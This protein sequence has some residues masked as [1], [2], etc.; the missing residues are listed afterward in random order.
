MPPSTAHS[1]VGPSPSSIPLS[2]GTSSSSSSPSSMSSSGATFSNS[3]NHSHSSLNTAAIAGITAAAVLIVVFTAGVLAYCVWRR[4]RSRTYEQG[5]IDK[6]GNVSGAHHPAAVAPARSSFFPDPYLVSLSP[7]STESRKGAPLSASTLTHSQESS[8][9]TPTTLR[10]NVPFLT[11]T[12]SSP[13][14]GTAY[15][16][17]PAAYMSSQPVPREGP[18]TTAAAFSE[19]PAR[20]ED[21]NP[22]NHDGHRLRDGGGSTGR[23]YEGTILSRP[24]GAFAIDRNAGEGTEVGE[25]GPPSYAAAVTAGHHSANLPVS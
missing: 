12:P 2:T 5:W 22:G 25:E 3:G 4:R 15:D 8:Y 13:S 9:P 18:W 24:V 20:G 23:R 1:S 7:A 6:D 21:A 10:G 14:S 11:A 17:S 19:R 16:I